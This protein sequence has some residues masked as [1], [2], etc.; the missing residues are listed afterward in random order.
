MAILPVAPQRAELSTRK[1]ARK[2]DH[3]DHAPEIGVSTVLSPL[4]YVRRALWESSEP[5]LLCY[6]RRCLH[7]HPCMGR[8]CTTA[9]DGHNK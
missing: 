3:R 1:A 7:L 6:H 4:G 9:P 8:G 2:D 5:D